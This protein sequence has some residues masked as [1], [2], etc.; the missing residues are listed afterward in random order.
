[1]SGARVGEIKRGQLRHT[2]GFFPLQVERT[3]LRGRPSPPPRLPHGP[4]AG[5]EGG[6]SGERTP[7]LEGPPSPPRTRFPSGRREL[8][9][10]AP[11]ASLGESLTS[12]ALSVCLSVCPEEGQWS[13]A[14]RHRVLPPTPRPVPPRLDSPN[15]GRCEQP[16]L[17]P[18]GPGALLWPWHHCRQWG[19]RRLA[20]GTRKPLWPGAARRGERSPGRGAAAARRS[21]EEGKAEARLLVRIVIFHQ[22]PAICV[23][24][25][26]RTPAVLLAGVTETTQRWRRANCICSPA[27]RSK[28]RP[29][30]GAGKR[31]KGPCDVREI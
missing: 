28:L 8:P 4:A 31:A 25:P 26:D 19:P 1:M 20:P 18:R 10:P 5:M 9:H 16:I 14:L 3:K 22:S 11:A 6:P 17:P 21:R 30:H 15:L 7:G 29:S 2:G 23:S 24:A 27:H 12:P 13:P